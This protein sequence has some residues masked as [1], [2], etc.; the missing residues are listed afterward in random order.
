MAEKIDTEAAEVLRKKCL[1][2]N[3]WPQ[4]VAG[5]EVAIGTRV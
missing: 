4:F 2:G 3:D 5:Q 1:S